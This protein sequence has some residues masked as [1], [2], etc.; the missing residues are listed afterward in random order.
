MDLNKL[1]TLTGQ[2]RI[3]LIAAIAV[4]MGGYFWAE[5]QGMLGDPYANQ[6]WGNQQAYSQCPPGMLPTAGPGSNGGCAAVPSNGPGYGPAGPQPAPYGPQGPG[7]GP[8]GPGYGPQ[9][10]GY[11]P[12]GPHA[13]GYGPQ[14]PGYGPQ[15]PQAPG[16]GPQTPGYGPQ[17]PGYGPQ[18]PNTGWNQAVEVVIDGNEADGEW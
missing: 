9:T 6:P 5:Q 12:Q 2:Q 13:P 4:G 8:Q 14:T 15:G 10:P 3:V 17:A 1:K 18:G 16:Y 7:Y 11:G